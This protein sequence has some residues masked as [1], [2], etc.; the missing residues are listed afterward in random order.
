MC[1]LWS[2][3]GGIISILCLLTGLLY[4]SGTVNFKLTPKDV[5]MF[6]IC[7]GTFLIAVPEITPL[8]LLSRIVLSLNIILL[9][10][11]PFRI[12]DELYQY[13]FS[14]LAVILIPSIFFY[15][16][17]I[18]LGI[19]LPSF[20]HHNEELG[21]VLDNHIFYCTNPGA[22]QRF[23]GYF[24]EPGHLATIMSLLLLCSRCD[25]KDW[26][27]IVIIVAILL[28]MSL[29][30]YVIAF[31]AFLSKSIS[32]K[33]LRKIVKSLVG[34]SILFIVIVVVFEIIGK[35]AILDELIFQRLVFDS[36]T[37]RLAGDNRVSYATNL[38]IATLDFNT[39]FWGGIDVEKYNLAGTGIKMYILQFGIIGVVATY[40]MYYKMLKSR[41][42][43]YGSIC[44]LVFAISFI[45]RCYAI[46]FCQIFMFIY[47]VSIGNQIKN[48]ERNHLLNN[49]P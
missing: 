12:L 9:L 22:S 14:A 49:N 30:G 6:L 20:V 17:D 1:W 37:G 36:D 44:L 16:L 35:S 46:W 18:S 26:R 8:I 13:V 28:S 40:L 25:L 24:C 31:L 34:V 33:G 48:N 47:C 29:A 19:S 5:T 3:D 23:C 11:W 7:L 45:Q 21:Y 39:L 2:I 4:G 42:S 10:K 43:K 41:P 27:T 15:I 32:A 38:F